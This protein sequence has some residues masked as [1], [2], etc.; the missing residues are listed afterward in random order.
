VQAYAFFLELAIEGLGGEFYGHDG[1][2]GTSSELI[3]V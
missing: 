2:H 3:Y 1:F